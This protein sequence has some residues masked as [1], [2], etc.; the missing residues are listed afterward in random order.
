MITQ[1][2]YSELNLA[3]EALEGNIFHDGLKRDVFHIVAEGQENA[4]ETIHEGSTFEGDW[5]DLAIRTI[6]GILCD[7]STSEEARDW[8][9]AQGVKF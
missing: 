1:P 7:R 3:Y 2:T 5:N 4:D 9:T 6:C 8:F